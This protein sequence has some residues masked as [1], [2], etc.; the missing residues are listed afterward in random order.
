MGNSLGWALCIDLG[1]WTTTLVYIKKHVWERMQ[2]GTRGEKSTCGPTANTG[3]W[4][5]RGRRA[6]NDQKQQRVRAQSMVTIL[7]LQLHPTRATDT[8]TY[9]D[10][11]DLCALLRLILYGLREGGDNSC[12]DQSSR[13]GG[14]GYDA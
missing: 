9:A 8:K 12:A 4:V 13:G 1:G 2:R 5:V 11:L 10:T 3:L 14:R 7:M 6:S